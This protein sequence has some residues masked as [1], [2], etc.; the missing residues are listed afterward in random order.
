MSDLCCLEVIG[1]RLEAGMEVLSPHFHLDQVEV[2]LHLTHQQAGVTLR[3][4]RGQQSEL[5]LAMHRERLRE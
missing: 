4:R 3:E 2:G 1:D 5:E